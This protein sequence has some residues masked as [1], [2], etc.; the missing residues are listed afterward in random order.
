MNLK[1][2]TTADRQIAQNDQA[3][4]TTSYQTVTYLDV[5]DGNDDDL[6]GGAHRHDF[7]FAIGL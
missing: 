1:E 4:K 5:P 3:N 6:L 7:R 2:M